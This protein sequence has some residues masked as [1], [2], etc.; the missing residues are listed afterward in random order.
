MRFMEIYQGEKPVAREVDDALAE[1]CA[2]TRQNLRIGDDGVRPTA[3]VDVPFAYGT[4][5][6]QTSK[7]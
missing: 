3:V 2:R 1:A 5:S 4:L 7:A 6:L